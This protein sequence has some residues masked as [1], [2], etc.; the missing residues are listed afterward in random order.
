MKEIEFFAVDSEYR[1]LTIQC[2]YFSLFT[3][4]YVYTFKNICILP[5]THIGVRHFL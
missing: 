1:V 3:F 4:L 2:I 5:S